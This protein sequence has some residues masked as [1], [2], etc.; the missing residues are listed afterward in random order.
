MAGI[1]GEEGHIQVAGLAQLQ[2][3]LLAQQVCSANE[4]IHAAHA[5]PCKPNAHLL[6]YEG[7]EVDL[8]TNTTFRSSWTVSRVC[9]GVMWPPCNSQGLL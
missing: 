6:C 8:Q 2:V 9:V 7:K 3:I 1:C 4:L 5:Q